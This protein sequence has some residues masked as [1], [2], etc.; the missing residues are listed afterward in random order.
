MDGDHDIWAS[1]VALGLVRMCR[2]RSLAVG[3]LEF[4]HE[5]LPL[6][7]DEKA[8]SSKGSGGFFTRDYELV[9]DAAEN[10]KGVGGTNL[11]LAMRTVINECACVPNAATDVERF[12]EIG[13]KLY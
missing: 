9:L 4:N 3:Y 6:R 2:Q 7:R 8:C 11:Q 1:A 12:Q 10:G 5:P 13:Q